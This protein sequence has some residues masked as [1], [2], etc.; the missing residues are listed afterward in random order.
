MWQTGPFHACGIGPRPLHADRGLAISANDQALD[1][2]G[3]QTINGLD[4]GFFKNAFGT[5]TAKHL[6]RE[7][8]NVM[9]IDVFAESVVRRTCQTR[10]HL[11]PVSY[12]CTVMADF[13]Y[14]TPAREATV[15]ADKRNARGDGLNLSGVYTLLY[16]TFMLVNA[17][18]P[19]V[20]ETIVFA[21]INWAVLSGL[22]LIISA[23]LLALV[24]VWLCRSRG[25]SEARP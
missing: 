19:S 24:Y 22:V 9:A 6:S 7:T 16:G 5:D 11:G 18:A 21:G 3:D 14:T 20:M 25:E 17:F 2:N 12:T 4:F 13:D 10:L 23:F 8:A 15:P 1:G